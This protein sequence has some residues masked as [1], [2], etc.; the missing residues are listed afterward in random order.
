MTFRDSQEAFEDAL[1]QG[2]LSP[3][4]TSLNYAGLY[5]YMGTDDDGLDLF[6]HINTRQYLPTPKGERTCAS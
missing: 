3:N 2:R 6:K 1:A 4:R 5:M